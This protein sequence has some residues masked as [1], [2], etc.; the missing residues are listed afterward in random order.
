MLQSSIILPSFV[1]LTFFV[2]MKSASSKYY[3][4]NEDVSLGFLKAM[5]RNVGVYSQ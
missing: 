3:V 2:F 1:A 5:Y 4:Y